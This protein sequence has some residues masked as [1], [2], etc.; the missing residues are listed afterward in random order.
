MTSQAK[1]VSRRRTLKLAAASATLPLVHIR[2]GRAAG[3]VSIGFWDHWV[4]EGNEIMKKQCEA[5]GA[6]HQVEVQA[7]FITS[8]GSKN[9]L[10]IAAEAQAKTGHDV[11]QFP[12]WE[13]QNHADQLEPIDD[14]MKRLTDKYGP[15][16]AASQYLFNIKGHWLAVPSSAGNQNKGP[17]GRISVLKDV[18]GLDIVKMYPSGADATPDADNWTYDT[19]LKVAEA[20]KKANMTVAVGLGTTPD[21]VDTAGS[22]FAAFGADLISAKGDIN[23]HTDNVRQ[24]LEYAQQLVKYLP[25][26]AVSFD[27]ASNNRALISGKS[28]L[29]WNP[30]SAWAVAKRDAP[31]VAADCWTFPAPKG[32]KGRFL[33]LGAFSWGV[34]N[35]SAN[36]AAAKDLIEF[37]SQRENVEARCTVTQGYDVPPFASMTD[38]KIWAEVEPPRGT[39]YHYPIRKSHHQ[40]NWIAMAPAPPEIAVQAY[41]RGTLPTMLAKLQSG[42]SI[43]EVQD[44]AQDELEGFTR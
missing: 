9:I 3:K 39:V 18:A 29:I 6:A 42:Q 28:A 44:W 19:L 43:K 1:K 35:F 2:T 38:F 20:C 25:E 33:P 32:P 7:D 30:P 5:F 15:V 26:D 40:E 34:W 17:C 31:K 21:S 37:L 36:K 13:V 8:V 27:D 16:A 4:P 10:T 22:M 24:V 12:E 14:V 41:N 11:Q 23:V